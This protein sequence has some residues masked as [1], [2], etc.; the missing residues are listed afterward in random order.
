[1]PIP[2]TSSVWSTSASPPRA[3]GGWR[4]ATSSTHS[5]RASCRRACAGGGQSRRLSQARG[6]PQENRW[7]RRERPRGGQARSRR[8][9]TELRRA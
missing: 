3:G 5:L 1:M 9:E 6:R 4:R 7:G 2:R 8:R